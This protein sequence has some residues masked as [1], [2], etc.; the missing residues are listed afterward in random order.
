MIAAAAVRS[1]LPRAISLASEGLGEG[2]EPFVNGDDLWF[3]AT[4][5]RDIYR[6]KL[7]PDGGV[8]P[9]GIVSEL[10]NAAMDLLPTV[11]RDGSTIYYGSTRDGG[12]ANKTSG[13]RTARPEA[14]STRRRTWVS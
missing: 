12:K 7:F 1:R 9:P 5:A 14:H 8:G 3:S 10:A 4:A 11:S 6:A 13:A 2:F